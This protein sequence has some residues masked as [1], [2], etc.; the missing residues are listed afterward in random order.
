MTNDFTVVMQEWMVT[1]K[2]LML[3]LTHNA[4]EWVLKGVY[5]HSEPKR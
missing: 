3:K 5:Q 1:T 2:V 4:G